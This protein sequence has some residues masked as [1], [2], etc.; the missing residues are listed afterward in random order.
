MV[1]YI[2]NTSHNGSAGVCCWLLQRSLLSESWLY[3]LQA[4]LQRQN[5]ML[6]KSL[7]W[8]GF[9]FFCWLIS[10]SY[11]YTTNGNYPNVRE[12]WSPER[13]KLRVF[14]AL[15]VL[16]KNKQRGTK[17]LIEFSSLPPF[18]A[19]IPLM[20]WYLPLWSSYR[21]LKKDQEKPK[22]NFHHFISEEWQ[23]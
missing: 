18:G 17:I 8:F 9:G 16:S 20:F 7:I 10:R 15:S 13:C 22:E 23:Q 2:S 4:N 1:G 21:V 19:A 12:Q 14:G 6:R 5:K 3:I 11:L